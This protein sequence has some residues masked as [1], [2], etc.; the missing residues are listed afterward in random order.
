MEC[1]NGFDT[2][3]YLASRYPGTFEKDPAKSTLPWNF[4]CYHTFYET[5][6]KEWDNSS[7]VLLQLGAGPCIWDL[8]SAA[9]YVA[10]AYHSDYL[11]G[12][13]DEV[14]L[15]RNNDPKAYDW[16][17][18]FRYVI[19]TLEGN[20]SPN[21]VV[22]REKMLRSVVKDSFTCDVQKSPLTPAFLKSPDIV[23]TNFC[24]E[25]SAVSKER[26]DAVLKEIFEM[27]R[28]NGFFTMLNSLECTYYTI[29]GVRFPCNVYLTNKYIEDILKE[30]GFVV[31]FNESRP[32][33]TRNEFNDTT[34]QSFFVAQKVAN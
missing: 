28:P 14:L 21:A 18:Y 1:N 23:C 12:C 27:L 33:P 31:R 29:N 4:Q 22:E 19:D 20:G 16:S 7:A 15:W 32:L 2:R 25:F 34:G 30:I 10:E 5:F 8:I 9:P 24:I 3:G 17:P 6:H 13:C 11:Q 26:Y